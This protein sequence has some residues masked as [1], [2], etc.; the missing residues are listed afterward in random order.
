MDYHPVPDVV[1]VDSINIDTP[2]PILNADNREITNIMN[3]VYCKSCKRDRDPS[4]FTDLTRGRTLKSCADCRMRDHNRR[5]PQAQVPVVVVPPIVIDGTENNETALIS[6]NHGEVA[7]EYSYTEHAIVPDLLI[8]SKN[9]WDSFTEEEQQILRE[10]AIES[11]QFHKELWA[12]EINH[13]IEAAKELG[14]T[15]HEDVNKDA[16]R[17]LVEPMH[18]QVRNNPDLTPYYDRIQKM[19]GGSD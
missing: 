2:N 11:S 10:A 8:F 9:R 19:S 7:K 1:D 4:L 14:V 15:F 16:F 18:E 3:L 6:T 12:E 5:N 13:S 17:E